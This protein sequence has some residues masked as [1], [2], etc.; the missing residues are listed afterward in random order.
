[1]ELV[2]ICALQ[3]RLCDKVVFEQVAVVSCEASSLFQTL[4]CYKTK[5]FSELVNL[6][7]FL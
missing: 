5:L 4:V 7:C 3:L 1:M 2:D 6:R